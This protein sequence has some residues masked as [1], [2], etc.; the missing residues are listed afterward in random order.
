MQSEGAY[1]QTFIGSWE[2]GDN[3]DFDLGNV[4]SNP[5]IEIAAPDALTYKKL[6]LSIA[7]NYQHRLTFNANIAEN[8]QRYSAGHRRSPP[9]GANRSPVRSYYRL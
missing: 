4:S 8:G 3:A 9:L 5:A 1:S 6:Y 2:S 7:G